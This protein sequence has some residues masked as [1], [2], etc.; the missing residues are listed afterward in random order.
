MH[1]MYPKDLLHKGALCY[2]VTKGHSLKKSTVF[3]YSVCKETFFS[4]ITAIEPKQKIENQNENCFIYFL[5]WW[6][7]KEKKTVPDPKP[8]YYSTL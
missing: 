4:M 6:N 2:Y 8:V 7:P 3:M 5:L 1:L